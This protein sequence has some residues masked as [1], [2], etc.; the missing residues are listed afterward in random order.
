[1]IE[2]FL[3]GVGFMVAVLLITVIFESYENKLNEILWKVRAT[4]KNLLKKIKGE[5]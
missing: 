4:A 3:F 1:M 5:G 2:G